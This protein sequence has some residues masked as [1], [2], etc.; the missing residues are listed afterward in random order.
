MGRGRNPAKTV[1]AAARSGPGA[2]GRAGRRLGPVVGLGVV[3]LI[4]ASCFSFSTGY[5]YESH[6]SPDGTNLYFKV[7]SQW[8]FYNVKQVIDAKNGPLSQSQINQIAAGQW[9][10][11]MSGS[12]HPTV[13]QS[14]QLGSAYPTGIIE[15]RQLDAVERDGLSFSAMRA[16]LL[17]TDPLQSASGLVTRSGFQLLSYS[18]FTKPGGIRGLKFVVNIVNKNQPITTFGQVVA[19]D[20]QTNWIFA[21]GMGCKASCWNTNSG[22]I[23]QVLNSWTLKETNP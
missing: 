8:T 12:P 6:R 11:S 22:L 14:L 5:S 18:D 21:L 16:E 9:V 10:E 20:A 7:P 15:G 13:S 17:G 2:L 4:A 1:G 19:V 23:D 3:A